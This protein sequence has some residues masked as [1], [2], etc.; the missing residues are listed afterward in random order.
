MLGGKQV[1][2]QTLKAVQG[3]HRESKDLHVLGGGVPFF[4]FY[5]RKQCQPPLL[6]SQG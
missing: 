2:T 4:F 6:P 1:G 3:T 5:L